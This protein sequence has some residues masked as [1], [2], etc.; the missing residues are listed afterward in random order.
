MP[1]LLGVRRLAYGRLRCA[2]RA[3]AP[4][5]AMFP[6]ESQATAV[7]QR[8]FEPTSIDSALVFFQYYTY[9]FLRLT[10]TVLS[11]CLRLCLRGD[12]ADVH[13]FSDRFQTLF[14]VH[15]DRPQFLVLFFCCLRNLIAVNFVIRHF[16]QDHELLLRLHCCGSRLAPCFFTSEI[17]TFF[18]CVKSLQ[19]LLSLL[20]VI[21]FHFRW[22][23]G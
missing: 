10:C 16:M 5:S 23:D 12:G 22:M 11:S 21:K 9:E 8:R 7:A 3:S 6:T 14:S 18:L 17:A 4:P 15:R 2:R 19:S 20:F 13:R 1:R